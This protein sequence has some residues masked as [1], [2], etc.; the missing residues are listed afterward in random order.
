MGGLIPPNND[1]GD[2]FCAIVVA[3]SDA[4]G[5]LWAGAVNENAGVVNENG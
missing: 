1:P 5:E 3:P 4:S 2:A